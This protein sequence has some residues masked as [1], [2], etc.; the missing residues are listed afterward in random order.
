M[1]TNIKETLKTTR[2][3]YP[4][5]YEYLISTLWKPL[6]QVE[7]G[8]K[9]HKVTGDSGGWTKYGISYNN[10]K[11]YFISLEDFKNMTEEEAQLIAFS[12]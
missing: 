9:L 11:N 5:D 1:K 12:K 3:Q 2:Y 7:G 10:N 4:F 8:A 6:M